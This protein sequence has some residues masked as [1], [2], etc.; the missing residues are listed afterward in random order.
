MGERGD[1]VKLKERQ[2]RKEGEVCYLLVM[3]SITYN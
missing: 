2:G 1:G 3:C